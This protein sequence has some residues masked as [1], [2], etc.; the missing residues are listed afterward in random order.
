M[1][2]DALLV[3]ARGAIR[4]IVLNRREQRNALPPAEWLR[5]AD[6]LSE[7]ATG[8]AARVISFRGTGGGA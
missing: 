3:E 5:L 8:Q 1:T 4:T 7:I 2:S 6:M